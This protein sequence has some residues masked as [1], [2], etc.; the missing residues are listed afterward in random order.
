MRKGKEA[1]QIGLLKSRAKQL[2][3]GAAENTDRIGWSDHALKRMRQRRVS[4]SQVLKVLRQ[5]KMIGN[6]SLDKNTGHWKCKLERYTA[7]DCLNVIVA[8][9][10]NED[11]TPIII[12]SAIVD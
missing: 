6:P 11:N 7:G 4:P 3:R 12:V 2:I 1:A 5:G 10:R 9:E 8:I